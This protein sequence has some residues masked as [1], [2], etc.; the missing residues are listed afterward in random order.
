MSPEDDPRESKHVDVPKKFTCCVICCAVIFIAYYKFLNSAMV[1]QLIYWIEKY[2][3][4]ISV[5]LF[6]NVVCSFPFYLYSQHII[7][8]CNCGKTELQL[9]SVCMRS[10][11]K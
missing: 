7:H 9:G 3:I 11:F 5:Y 8:H 4:L 10:R 2:I 1:L 6:R